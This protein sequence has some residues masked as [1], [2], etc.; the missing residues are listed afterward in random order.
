MKKLKAI[1][2]IVNNGSRRDEWEE[3]SLLHLIDEVLEKD[4]DNIDSRWLES[5]VNSTW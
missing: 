2:Y 4:G 3:S 1:E 5:R